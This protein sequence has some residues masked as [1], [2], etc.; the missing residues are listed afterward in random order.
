MYLFAAYDGLASTINPVYKI[1]EMNTNK[2]V[3]GDRYNW[4]YSY[5]IRIPGWEGS[6]Y[7]GGWR[8]KA[9]LNWSVFM[10]DSG[11]IQGGEAVLPQTIL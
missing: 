5:E 9:P 7:I 8:Y 6:I 10:N 2:V 11:Y 4:A 3:L 1:S